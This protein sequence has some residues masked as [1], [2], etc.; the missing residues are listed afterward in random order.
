MTLE[1][2]LK[3]V[4]GRATFTI[5]K[6]GERFLHEGT[7]DYTVLSDAEWEETKELWKNIEPLC[8]SQTEWWPEVK[9]QGVKSWNVLE[10]TYSDPVIMIFLD[11]SDEKETPEAATSRE[12]GK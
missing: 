6:D 7:Y 9:D 1:Q 10:R 3:P 8:I 4:D 11:A 2:F 12:S 5:Y